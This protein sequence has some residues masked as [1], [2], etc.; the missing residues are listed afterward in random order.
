MPELSID[1][2]ATNPTRAIHL[3]RSKRQAIVQRCAA[4][5][6]IVSSSEA[7]ET[8]ALKARVLNPAEA[9]EMLGKPISWMKRNGRGLPGAIKT[10]RA[11]GWS[12]ESL[13]KYIRM[14]AER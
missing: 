4:V 9:A 3:T 1:E 11:W 8:P 14:K 10:G 12:E 2:I 7:E 6:A 5:I 13:A